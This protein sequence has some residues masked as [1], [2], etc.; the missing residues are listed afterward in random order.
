MHLGRVRRVGW[1]PAGVLIMADTLDLRCRPRGHG[2]CECSC[3]ESG[4]WD[5]CHTRGPLKLSRSILEG[6]HDCHCFEFT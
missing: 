3:A 2:L 1:G 6:L 4:N 5:P